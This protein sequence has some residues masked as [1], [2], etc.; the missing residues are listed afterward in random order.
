MSVK[1]PPPL[2]PRRRHEPCPVCGEISY[3]LGGIHPQ[4]SVRQ[5]DAKRVERIKRKAKAKKKTE[6]SP[7]ARKAWQKPCP[8][9]RT[10]QHVRKKTCECGHVFAPRPPEAASSEPS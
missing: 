2:I 10:M 6:K 3:S 8:K 1:K 5:A 9:C 7:P 4:C